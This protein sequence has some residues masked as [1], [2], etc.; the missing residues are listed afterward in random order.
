MTDAIPGMSRRTTVG[1]SAIV[2][3]HPEHSAPPYAPHPA[4]RSGASTSSTTRNKPYPITPRR[5]A[6]KGQ[7]LLGRA[8]VGERCS[9]YYKDVRRAATQRAEHRPATTLK[10]FN[11][12]SITR[13]DFLKAGLAVGGLSLLE[14]TLPTRAAAKDV[15]KIGVML[16]SSGVYTELGDHISKGMRLYFDE[17]RNTAGGRE[18]VVI[19]ENE[20]S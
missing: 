17:V 11:R 16:P 14:Q 18:I 5:F 6:G 12:M 9:P 3:Q 10:E 8:H 13:R 1:V 7:R 4:Q 15:L 19:N 2:A 20:S